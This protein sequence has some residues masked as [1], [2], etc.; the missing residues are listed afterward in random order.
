MQSEKIEL[1]IYGEIAT[2]WLIDDN[3]I[4]WRMGGAGLYS[5]ISAAKQGAKVDF[6]TV[7]APKV[8]EYSLSVWRGMGIDFSK[9][10]MDEKYLL[11]NYLVT[12]YSKYGKKD[13]IPTNT[14]R[15]GI[16]YEPKLN[17]K[18]D[19]LVIFPID[20]SFPNKTIKQANK[21]NIP[22]ILDPKPN[23]FS[24][25][26]AKKIITDYKIKILLINEEELYLLTEQVETE[27][28]FRILKEKNVEI[29]ILKQGIKGS[30]VCDTTKE[31]KISSYESQVFCTLGS[32]DVYDGALV[33]N[34]CKG[35]NV[36]KS[37]EIASCVA[38]NFIEQKNIENIISEDK[39]I[40][41]MEERKKYLHIEKTIYL[42]G[43]FFSESEYDWITKVCNVLEAS[44]YKVI[45]PVRDIGPINEGMDKTEKEAIVKQD[46][47]K[48]CCADC[49]VAVVDVYD[50]GTFFEIGYAK[51][52]GISVI[53]L[54]TN[55]VK[56]NNMIEHGCDS[57]VNSLEELVKEIGDQ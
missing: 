35:I 4:V 53:G 30:I 45:S 39:V 24:I 10:K 36:F 12:G 55:S 57:I 22:V 27:R 32:G 48:I 11:P 14:S 37:A 52:K 54:K 42:A 13:S 43:P 50:P 19:A 38:A 7:Y 41:E 40:K 21:N 49:V 15:I 18:Y 5:A 8:D 25:A 6:F 23:E 16:D 9:A 34:Y 1:A 47:E 29:I 3:K 31:E 51:S 44:G 56:L 28:A 46:I 26:Q 33:A 17:K 2:D 20:H